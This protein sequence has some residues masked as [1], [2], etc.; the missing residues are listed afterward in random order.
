[1]DTVKIE[2]LPRNDELTAEEMQRLQGGGGSTADLGSHVT[3][4]DLHIQKYLDK[5]SIILF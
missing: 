1:M 3:H 2:D 5:A 4:S